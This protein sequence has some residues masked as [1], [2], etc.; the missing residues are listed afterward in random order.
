ME[1]MISSYPLSHI[2]RLTSAVERD[3][4][5]KDYL[6]GGHGDYENGEHLSREEP[7]KMLPTPTGATYFAKATR[8]MLTALNISSQ[9][10][11]IIR[12]AVRLK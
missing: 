7:A 1:H 5:A 8:A 3:D 6:S 10:D 4:D 11:P 9:V 12:T 2:H